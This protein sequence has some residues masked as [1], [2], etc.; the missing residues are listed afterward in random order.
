VSRRG[1]IDLGAYLGRIGL[2][3]A[4]SADLDGL[5]ALHAAHVAAIGFDDLDCALG[6]E[7]D[8]RPG[9]V[10]EKL[11]GRRRGGWCHEHAVLF[12]AVLDELGFRA[13]RLMA[14]MRPGRGGPRTHTLLRV[15]LDTGDVLAEPGLGSGPLEP[16]ALAPAAP[17]PTL[18]GWRFGLQRA[19]ERRWRLL[20]VRD[21]APAALHEFELAPASDADIAEG[22][23]QAATHP[24]SPFPGRVVAM[25]R[26]PDRHLRLVGRALTTSTPDGAE[27]QRT[28]Q[29]EEAL[30]LLTGTFAVELEPG[31]R[32]AVRRL[33]GDG[34]G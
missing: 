16:L 22:N 21:G 30:A 29:T 12:G 31:D 26:T 2:P 23:R 18:G 25:Q 3:A 33:L 32:D 28:L 27:E 4:P 14:D 8:L 19:D 5:R 13:D 17:H 20:H 11:V 7:P 15:R 34:P 6:R 10:E 1:Q 24:D 9:A